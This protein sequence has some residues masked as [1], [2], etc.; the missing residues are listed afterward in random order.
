VSLGAR[1]RPAL[2]S[3]GKGMKTR[4]LFFL[5][6]LLVVCALFSH[7]VALRYAAQSAR[8]TARAIAMPATAVELRI[9]RSVINRQS[10]VALFVGVACAVLSSAFAVFSRR[11]DESAPRSIVVVLLVF[12]GILHF[13]VV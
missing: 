11:A 7:M 5:A 1:H 4:R 6:L 9:Q 12:Y 10:T 3:R 8:L 2:L 13:A